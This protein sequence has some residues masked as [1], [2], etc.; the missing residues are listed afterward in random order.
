MRKTNRKKRLLAILVLV[1][2]V[3]GLGYALLSQD[4]TINGI[5][6]VKGNN[7]DIHF[8]NVVVN[9]SSV[10]LADNDSAATIDFNDD[11]LVNYTV[12]LNQPGDFYE[13]TVDAVNAGTVDGMIG[14]VISKING[15]EI[16]STN[17][18]PSYLNYSVRYADAV[19]I[20]ANQLLSVG[21]TETYK[22]RVEFKREI[23][24]DELPSTNQTITF[25]FGVTYI[26]A[27]N[28]AF[29]KPIGPTIQAVE[30]DY[31]EEWD[32]YDY[33]G[34][35]TRAFRSNTYRDKIKTITLADQISP[36]E[37]VVESW[38]IGV[39]QNGDVMAYVTTNT[40]DNTMYDL[41]IQGDGALN[42]NP[43]SG[44]LFSYLKG[45]DAI[46]NLDIL[47]IS[48]VT[49]MISM[50]DG[51]G[52]NSQVFTLDLGNHFDTSNVT[53]MRYIFC[54][55]GHNST[56]FTL[57]L[58]DSFDTSNVVDMEGMFEGTGYSSTVFTL[59]LGDRFDTSKVTNMNYLFYN[60]GYSNQNFTLNLGDKFDTSKVTKMFDM[61]YSTGHDS[62]IFTLDLGDKFDTSNVIDMGHMFSETGYS[63]P[64]FTLILGDSFNTSKVTRMDEMFYGTGY[65]SLVF[66][67]D[68]GDSFD[69]S[70]V[71][72]MN[73]MFRST[74]YSSLVF[75][76]DLG[77]KFDTSKVTRMDEMFE[78]VGYNS[79]VFTL[80]LG[81]IFNTSKVTRMRAMFHNAGYNSTVFTLDLGDNF[82]T[83]NVTIM[84]RMFENTGYRS[85]IFT[86]DLGD[87]FDTTKATDLYAFFMRTGYAN[88]N[89]EL[90]L[91]KFVFDNIGNYSLMFDGFRE[92]N[93]IW[94]KNAADQT[95]VINHKGT[96]DLSTANV[97][98]KG[99]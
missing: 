59:N 19:T 27:D 45:V 87:K 74:G 86:L 39:N 81:N 33:Y 40:T 88:A 34:V 36:P 65:N 67:L 68:L 15:T 38:D 48:K 52:Y 32:Y 12:T 10:V 53:N 66:K 95:W 85:T 76:L 18:I 9:S 98:I 47:N 30:Y 55:T 28:N 3:L 91:S 35:D 57:N 83:S 62:L 84:T 41:Y 26:Q 22:V 50:F 25:S 82:N 75:T 63:N 92:T 2:L 71:T 90:D 46:N 4:L 44:G 60:T 20:A 14:G 49:N 94:V 24:N 13:F 23:E 54:N 97:L 6:K 1:I 70:K 89:L 17:P 99:T 21:E 11:T 56:V 61:F 43:N 64:N 29:E 69:T 72:D 78:D 7:W 16:S 58:G 37:N 93:K 79:P 5:T 73:W 8:D 51:V 31:D 42:A 77:D 80:N 96:A